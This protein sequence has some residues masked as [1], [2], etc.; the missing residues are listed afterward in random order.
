MADLEETNLLG[1]HQL[2]ID[3]LSKVKTLY[4]AKLDK[5]LFMSLKVKYPVLFDV[6]DKDDY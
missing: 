5:E 2:T 6:P 1:T 4:S 3:Q